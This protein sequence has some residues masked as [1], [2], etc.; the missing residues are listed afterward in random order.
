MAVCIVGAQ[1]VM[2]PVALAAGRF[3]HSSGRK[4]VFLIGF[5]ALPIRGAL[6]TVSD[7]PYYLVGVQ[8]MDG[9]GAAIFGVVSVLVIADLIRGTGRFNFI[10]GVVATATGLGASL[11][12]GITGFIVQ[13]TGFNAAFLFLAAI[14]AFA[15]GIFWLFM[16]ETKKF[17]AMNDID[18]AAPEVQPT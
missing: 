14:A 15:L 1:T 6:Y 13:R 17:N 9:I 2:I 8:L 18:G 4:A 16:P 10:Q 11:S 12:N 5:A 7:N 3:A